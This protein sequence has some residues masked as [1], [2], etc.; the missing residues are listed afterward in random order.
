MVGC[1]LYYE[2]EDIRLWHGDSREA[3]AALP[4]GAVDYIVTDPPYGVKK[5]GWDVSA[6]DWWLKDAARASARAVVFSPGIR[7]LLSFP[8]VIDEKVY[9]WTLSIYIANAIVRGDF[10]FG[11]W[12]PFLVYA[13]P[14]V[15]L[16]RL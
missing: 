7:N 13:A 14:D 8:P 3:L 16:C 2:S 11:N 12:I 15:S 9:R 1:K 5:A 10:G 6:P 4:D